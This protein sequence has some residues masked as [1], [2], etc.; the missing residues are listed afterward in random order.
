MA[1]IPRERLQADTNNDLRSAGQR[2]GQVIRDNPE[3]DPGRPPG[4]ERAETPVAEE[5]APPVQPEPAPQVNDSIPDATEAPEE[6]GQDAQS[7]EAETP[8]QTQDAPSDTDASEDAGTIELD[9]EQMSEY[10]GVPVEISEDGERLLLKTKV[11]GEES[12]VTLQDALTRYQ[13]EADLTRKS[14]QVAEVQKQADAKLTELTDT[15]RGEHAKLASLLQAAEQSLNPYASVNWEQ[16]KNEDPDR[17]M[18]MRADA[19]DYMQRLNQ[20]KQEAAQAFEQ[21]HNMIRD[22]TAENERAEAQRQSDHLKQLIPDWSDDLEAKLVSYV[23]NTYGVE[24]GDVQVPRAW[25]IDIAR[26]AMMFDEGAQ[27]VTDKK[28]KKVPKYIR[29][30]ARRSATTDNSMQVKGATGAA[31]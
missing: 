6:T 1:R 28:V 7:V 16:L 11:N 23:S 12:T 9:A 25:M 8:D 31:A 29:P 18:I 2:I 3:L 19:S 5:A 14:M 17:W 26:K 21:H 15:L 10:L 13:S 22:E 27:K 20:V 4:Y 30:K 24:A